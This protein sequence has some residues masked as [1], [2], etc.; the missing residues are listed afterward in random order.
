LSYPIR[1]AASIASLIVVTANANAQA[2]TLADWRSDIADIVRDIRTLHPDPFARTGRVTFLRAV[3]DLET[4]LPSLTTEQR[5]ARTMALVAMLEDGH[6]Y[7][8]MNHPRYARWYPVRLYEFTDGYFIVSA[9]KSAADVAGAQVLEIGGAPVRDV[10]EKASATMGYENLSMR[11]ERVDPMH[12]ETL[13]RALGYARSDGA[14]PVKLRLSNGRVVDRVLTAAQADHPQF[15]DDATWEWQFRPELF[16]TPV[17]TEQDWTTAYR[18]LPASAFQTADSSRPLFLTDRRPF[19]ARSVPSA[20]AVYVRTN[21]IS[22]TDFLPFFQG[23]MARVDSMRPEKLIIDWRYNFGGDGSQLALVLREFIKRADTPPWKDIYILTG[24]KTFSAAVLAL[25][26]FIE[27]LPLTIVG[28]PSAAG[29]NHFGDPT[30]R[31]YARTGLRLSVSTVRHQLA[32]SSDL[33]EFVPVDVPAQFTFADFTAGRDPAVDPIIRGDEM[34]SI[35]VIARTDGGAAARRA[36]ETRRRAFSGLSWWS[37]PKEFTM[38]QACDALQKEKRFQ[39]ALET[40]R[41]T[42]DM[43]PTTWNVWYNLGVAQRAAGLMKERLA[44]YRCVVAIAPDNWN[45]PA[46]KRLLA[47]PGNEGTELAPGCPTG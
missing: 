32:E 19:S 30:N 24:R 35:P 17:G 23:V 39:D 38:R 7:L 22:D 26:K 10:A 44:S 29:L 18:G 15:K 42:A 12:S 16:G 41:L 11:A 47:Q 6:T 45:V 27:F 5:V 33:S 4:A 13:M 21:Y 14:L 34:R 1:I 36:Y 37:P 31:S 46:L 28:E 20:K 40:C 2:P 25:G 9:F 8:E 43:H 3:R